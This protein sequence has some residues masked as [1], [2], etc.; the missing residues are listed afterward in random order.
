MWSASRGKHISNRICNDGRNT[1]MKFVICKQNRPNK[2]DG[3]Y[4]TMGKHTPVSPK[5]INFC[6]IKF[7]KAK[8]ED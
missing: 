1:Y 3:V 7:L 6:H 5:S 8:T 4:V 2:W